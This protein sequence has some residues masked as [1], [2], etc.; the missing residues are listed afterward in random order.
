ML[1]P[2]HIITGPT[3]AGKSARALALAEEKNGVIIN[4]D[5]MQLYRELRVLTARPSSEEERRT[6]HRLYG[7]LP[8]GVRC[9]A[10]RWVRLAENAIDAAHRAGR[11]PILTG[12]TGLYLRAL[13]EGLS[14]IPDIPLAVREEAQGLLRQ[15]GGEAFHKA[16]TE[17]DPVLAARLAPGDSQRMIRAWEVVAHTGRPLSAWQRCDPLRRYDPA[18]FS[19]ELVT[20]SRAEI[21]ARCDARFLAMMEQ[22]AEEEVRELLAFEL[23]EDLPA[24]RAVGV[25]E[26]AGWLRGEYT[27]EEAVRRGQQATRH[28]AKRQLTWLRHQ[29][30]FCDEILL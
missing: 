21:Y 3:A 9:S 20:R 11:L 4:A 2:I 13:T 6:P 22:G 23:A 15:W 24:M 27:R 18:Q 12:G 1:T 16:L 8:A 10:A 17:K 14:P 25:P 30:R 28:Y 19:W 29:S 26:I 5:A 7:V